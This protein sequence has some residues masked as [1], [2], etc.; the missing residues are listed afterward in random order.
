MQATKVQLATGGRILSTVEP[1]GFGNGQTIETNTQ[2]LS[3]A[4]NAQINANT[5]GVGTAGRVQITANLFDV[6]SGGQLSTITTGRGAAR[7]ILI[8]ARDRLI[9]TGSDNGFFANTAV[10]SSSNSGGI[11]VNTDRLDIQNGAKIAIG[12][13]GQRQGV[14]INIQTN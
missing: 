12:S 7:N 13:Q 14:D 9:L 11:I 6:N 4:S 10:D 8:N 2:S 3:L 1:T 5:A